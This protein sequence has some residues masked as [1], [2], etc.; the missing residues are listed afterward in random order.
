[1]KSKG[2]SMIELI[3]ATT[4]LSFL[5]LSIATLMLEQKKSISLLEDQLQKVELVRNLETILRN[6][7]A[8]QQTLSGVVIPVSGT[9]NV[10]DLKDNSGAIIYSSNTDNQKLRIGQITVANSSVPGPSS[11][12]FVDIQIPIS[13]LFRG[14][15]FKSIQM[16]VNV[17]VDA[18]RAVTSCSGMGLICR[19]VTANGFAPP[20]FSANARCNADE[21]AIG[22]GGDCETPTGGYCAGLSTGI[23]HYSGP[24]PD[25]KGW[26]TDCFSSS[27]SSP[28]GDRCSRAFAR[29]CKNN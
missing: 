16:K 2:F 15:A 27:G 24:D 8:C 29:C 5:S 14:L 1:M 7:L 12:G 17:T 23:L 11:S 22:G 13:S 3:V 28:G 25:G 6:G 18:G 10:T 9:T 19:T 21:F 4:I 26:S 20:Y